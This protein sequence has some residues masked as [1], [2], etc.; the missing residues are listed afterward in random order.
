ML[1][2]LDRNTFLKETI[3][4]L[5][6]FPIHHLCWFSVFLEKKPPYMRLK[7]RFSK[8]TKHKKYW[9]NVIYNLFICFWD[10][11]FRNIFLQCSGS[12]TQ[13]GSATSKM[14][15]QDVK[16]HVTSSWWH[17]R[18]R[19]WKPDFELIHF[20][21]KTK[22]SNIT[23]HSWMVWEVEQLK[24]TIS[25]ISWEIVCRHQTKSY[26]DLVWLFYR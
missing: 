24:K 22:S 21:S 19:K 14:T 9:Q 10:I 2:T 4:C 6:C 8:Q 12:K 26:L 11:Y 5:W 7:Q 25:D 13:K 3:K 23:P 17:E 16:H 18:S 15:S 1:F 20:L